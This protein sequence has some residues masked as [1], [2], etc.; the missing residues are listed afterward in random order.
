MRTWC[1]S[2][3]W[4][5]PPSPP[6]APS[7]WTASAPS[8]ARSPNSRTR[9]GKWPASGCRWRSPPSRTATCGRRPN[10]PSRSGSRRRPA[11]RCWRWPRPSTA[12][13]A[14][15]STWPPSRPCCVATPR[16]RWSAWD[17]ATR[18]WSG[19]SSASSTSWSTRTPT[20]RPWPTSSSSTTWPPGCAA[21]RRACW[22]W[23]ASRAP[24]RGRRRCPSPTCCAPRSPRSRST[25]GW[26]CAGSSRSGCPAR[27]WPRSPTCSPNWS[28]TR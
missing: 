21:T 27:W 16:S 24:A 10:R 17:A 28:R 11:P 9:R 4:R 8:P 23:P 15:P 7:P 3:C 26:C 22:C 12:S 20:R 14:P 25:G 2:G 5:S 19:A 1:S 13:S 18:T 6:S